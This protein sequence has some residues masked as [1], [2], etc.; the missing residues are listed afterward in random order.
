MKTTMND[1][2]LF[3][4]WLPL[5]RQLEIIV[6]GGVG[7]DRPT[8]VSVDVRFV[9]LQESIILPMFEYVLLL[10]F[11][12]LRVIFAVKT[13]DFLFLVRKLEWIFVLYFAV[14]VSLPQIW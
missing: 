7:D 4:K 14:V 9:F 2:S 10:G 6:L 3:T 11:T 8:D 1:T 13:E 5:R 12:V